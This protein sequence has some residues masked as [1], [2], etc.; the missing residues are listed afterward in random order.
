MRHLNTY[1][2]GVVNA[3][4]SGSGKQLSILSAF[5][6]FDLKPYSKESGECL[7]IT[8]HST[9]WMIKDLVPLSTVSNPNF[10]KFVHSLNQ[11]YTMPCHKTLSSVIIPKLYAETKAYLINEL[12]K[13]Q[14]F[15]VTSIAT[16]SNV[17]GM[18]ELMFLQYTFNLV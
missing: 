18:L 5:V 17:T 11:R 10:Q 12:E 15:G 4:C 6:K 1:H 3:G 7:D 16:Q 8:K 14:Y 9:H 13:F 2:T